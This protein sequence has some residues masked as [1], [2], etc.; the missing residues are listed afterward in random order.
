MPAKKRHTT[1]RVSDEHSFAHAHLML[2]N[3][4]YRIS[5]TF[6]GMLPGLPSVEDAVA[7]GCT[8]VVAGW[9]SLTMTDATF[10]HICSD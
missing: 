2:I 6:R 4:Y 5:L 9:D 3:T 7:H 10:P 8:L 1:F